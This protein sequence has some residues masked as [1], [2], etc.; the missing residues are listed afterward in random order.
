MNELIDKYLV[1]GCMRCKLGATPNCKVHSWNSELKL[2]RKIVLDSSL[3]EELKW[4][5]PCYTYKN[6]NICIVSAFKE[7]V[8]LSFFKGSLLKDEHQ[9]LVKQGEN[10]Q[11]S[12]ILKFQSV[13]EILKI[14]YRIKEYLFEAIEI[15]NQGLKIDYNTQE[16]EIPSELNEMFNKNLTFKNAFYSLTKGR[17]KGYILFFNQAKQSKT[18]INRIEKYVDKIILGK[19]MNEY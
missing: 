12:R 14:E 4:S 11:A 9:I 18:R 1:D 3:Q 10:S 16:L 5:V 7:Y 15:E 6:K 19:G 2:L 17:Q 8:C 13:D